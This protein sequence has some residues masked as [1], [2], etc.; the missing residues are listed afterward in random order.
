MKPLVNTMIV[1]FGHGGPLF[2][3]RRGY[4]WVSNV[5]KQ[6]SIFLSFVDGATVGAASPPHSKAIE[7]WP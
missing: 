7:A 3:L 6:T 4:V 1:G 5:K 2:S